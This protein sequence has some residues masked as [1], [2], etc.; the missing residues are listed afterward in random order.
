M[1]S[2]KPANAYGN[3]KIQEW[4]APAKA[5]TIAGKVVTATFSSAITGSSAISVLVLPILAIPLTVTPGVPTRTHGYGTFPDSRFPSQL[6]WLLN[7]SL[8][9]SCGSSSH[10]N[11]G[12][13]WILIDAV[14]ATDF[15]LQTE[16]PLANGP[17]M[18]HQSTGLWF[19]LLYC[20]WSGRWH[21][22][23]PTSTTARGLTV[24]L[25]AIVTTPIRLLQ[26]RESD[27]GSI[28]RFRPTGSTGALTVTFNR[29]VGAAGTYTTTRNN[30]KCNL[31][32]SLLT[33]PLL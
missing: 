32:Q 19:R 6:I 22:F 31:P 13:G 33:P 18:A 15:E 23:A 21:S 20:C 26:N 30:H 1:D 17:S 9:P 16:Y 24:D 8:V 2:E 7:F 25:G 4:T 14:N 3:F 28:H 12:S 29:S 27:I 11:C 5:A 10:C